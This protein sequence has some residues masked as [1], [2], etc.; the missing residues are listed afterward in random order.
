MSRRWVFVIGTGLLLAGLLAVAMLSTVEAGLPDE[1]EAVLNR[2]LASQRAAFEIDQVT[3]ARQPERLN[4]S[5]GQPLTIEDQPGGADSPALYAGEVIRPPADSGELPLPPQAAWCVWLVDRRD[6][7][8]AGELIVV[9]Q[10]EQLYGEQW[11][12]FRVDQ[13]LAAQLGCQ[14]GS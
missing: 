2:Y 6:E 3:P 12:L 5:M 7:S 14:V 10:H 8:L 9:T 4:R 13:A 1:A 11:G